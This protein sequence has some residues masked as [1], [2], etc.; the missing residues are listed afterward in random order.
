MIGESEIH[1]SDPFGT[2]RLLNHCTIAVQVRVTDTPYVVFL[3]K[4]YN[5]NTELYRLWLLAEV[6]A[7]S[8]KALHSKFS[9]WKSDCLE[10][11]GIFDCRWCLDFITFY[12]IFSTRIQVN[13]LR[14]G[15]HSPSGDASKKD[16]SLLIFCS[17]LPGRRNYV[18]M[19]ILYLGYRHRSSKSGLGVCLIEVLN[20]EYYFHW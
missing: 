10:K 7:S 6:M 4:N 12:Q 3:L 11:G 14:L 2:D 16:T 19:F 17:K 20:S 1:T 13:Q 5:S 9:D 8:S 15:S 18:C